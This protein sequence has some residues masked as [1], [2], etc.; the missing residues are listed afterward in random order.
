MNERHEDKGVGK[1]D[2]ANDK[3]T[4]ATKDNE[5]DKGPMPR[6]R[7]VVTNPMGMALPSRVGP[8]TLHM[9]KRD[10]AHGDSDGDAGKMDE[11]ESPPKV[12]EG[13]VRTDEKEG[14]KQVDQ[15]MEEGEQGGDA[16]PTEDFNNKPAT[17]TDSIVAV[18]QEG[19]SDEAPNTNT[20]N[21]EGLDATQKLWSS[22]PPQRLAD[23]LVQNLGHA[24]GREKIDRRGTHYRRLLLGAVKAFPSFCKEIA[25]SARTSRMKPLVRCIHE[26]VRRHVPHLSY[27]SI[28]LVHGAARAPINLHTHGHDDCALRGEITIGYFDGGSLFRTGFLGGGEVKAR[29]WAHWRERPVWG[30]LVSARAGILFNAYHLHRPTRWRGETLCYCMLHKWIV[31]MLDACRSTRT[32]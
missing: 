7:L 20:P 19:K 2:S 10:G 12:D 31:G 3:V 21:K 5:K 16:M 9:A 14:T 22:P 11:G 6:Q 27:T 32:P 25:I 15:P 23:M 18:A 4:D 26:F 17:P 24:R 8:A 30:R 29:A 28:A 13:M 1:E